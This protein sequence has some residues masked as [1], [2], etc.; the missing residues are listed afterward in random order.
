MQWLTKPA[1]K[2]SNSLLS[3]DRYMSRPIIRDIAGI[4]DQAEFVPSIV[5][6]MEWSTLFFHLTGQH[7]IWSYG[8]RKALEEAYNKDR[9]AL[10]KALIALL[11]RSISYFNDE[12][13]KYPDLQD[14]Y[15]KKISNNEMLIAKLERLW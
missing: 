14:E 13:S 7:I 2:A 6:K 8:Y 9:D 11:R 10:R 3:I 4:Y 1:T 15:R 5:P 12:I